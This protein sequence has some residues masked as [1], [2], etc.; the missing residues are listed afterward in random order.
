MFLSGVPQLGVPPTPNLLFHLDTRQLPSGNT[1]AQDAQRSPDKRC[2]DQP[3]CHLEPNRPTH[4]TCSR[5]LGYKGNQ[6]RCGQLRNS[7]HRLDHLLLNLCSAF[8]I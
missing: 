7:E 2:K 3:D 1:L 5:R 4:D 8:L 6:R